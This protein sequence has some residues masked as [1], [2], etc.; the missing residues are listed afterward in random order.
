MS[1]INKI[2]KTSVL[3]ALLM[4]SVALKATNPITNVNK[5]PNQNQTEI[6]SK[7]G[8]A[9]IKTNALQGINQTSVSTTHNKRIE[10]IFRKFANNDNEKQQVN[11][12]INSTYSAKG[13]FL[14]SALLQHEL[15]RQQLFLLL[16]EKGDVL[17]KNNLNQ[18]LGKKVQS[19]GSDFYK[20]VRPNA[21]VVSDWLDKKYSPNLMGLLAFNNKPN[22]EEVINKI[23]YIAQN[24]A[25]FT[26][27][28][29]LYYGVSSGDFKRKY[30]KNKTDDS[31]LSELIAYKIFLIDKII[32]KKTL[33][34]NNFFGENSHFNQY[35][36]L[37][38]FYDRWVDTVS[39]K[40]YIHP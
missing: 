16:E 30:I 32:F 24:K 14:A 1:A 20:S 5:T 6:V 35:A 36:D 39:P 38:D 27:D 7:E 37:E 29:I 31:S 33:K 11:A 18:E 21:K 25:N 15:D 4:G 26:S 22:A 17:V 40:S 28:D 3:G 13:T 23:D 10:T 34:N 9:A 8:A 19:F 12:L 2:M